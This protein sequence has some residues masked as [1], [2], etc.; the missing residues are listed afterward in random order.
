MLE[1]AAA[2]EDYRLLRANM[3]DL[4]EQLRGRQR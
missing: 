4:L 3:L 1:A 2:R